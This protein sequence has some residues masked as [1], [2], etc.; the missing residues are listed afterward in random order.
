MQYFITIFIKTP[1]V[2]YGQCGPKTSKALT[3]C[4]Y[5]TRHK[6]VPMYILRILI[7]QGAFRYPV[8]GRGKRALQP[9]LIQFQ[10]RVSDNKKIIPSNQTTKKST[11]SIVGNW[12]HKS[13]V[14]QW[15]RI[16]VHKLTICCCKYYHNIET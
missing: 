7:Y 10:S 12:W 2:N 8:D 14:F 1:E 4:Y 15:V 6:R 13:N 3:S 5:V 11:R 16:K 9:Y